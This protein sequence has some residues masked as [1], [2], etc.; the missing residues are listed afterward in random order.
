MHTLFLSS[1]TYSRKRPKLRLRG[2]KALAVDVMLTTCGEPVDMI[3]DTVRAACALD[4]PDDRYRIIVCDDGADPDLEIA[5]HLLAQEKSQLFYHARVK[6]KIHNYKAG[7]LQAGIEYACT[8]PDGPGQLIATLDSDMIPEAYWL[9][10]LVPH[11]LQDEKMAL[12]APPQ[13]GLSLSIL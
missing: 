13:V 5:V 9:N 8:L 3:M 4:Y 1:T 6:G 11:I 10:G 2:D 12:V 7:N